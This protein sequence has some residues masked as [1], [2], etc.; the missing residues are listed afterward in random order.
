MRTVGLIALGLMF[1]QNVASA[2]TNDNDKPA[3]KISKP[4]GGTTGVVGAAGGAIAPEFTPLTASERWKRYFVDAFG[5]EAIVRAAASGGVNQWKGTPKEWGGGAE[6]FGERVGNSYAEHIIRKT[7]EAGAAAALHEDNR[8]I[9]STETAFWKRSKHAI[10]SVFV[11]RN[12]AGQE[13]FA[14]SRFGSAWGES[15]ISRTWQPR[16]V[17]SAGDATV[18][19]GITMAADMGWNAVREFWPNRF[20]RH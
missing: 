12:E 9:R 3:V 20:K 5:P 8:Y 14:Y 6:A 19:F 4:D 17:N 13:H 1:W 11:A 15:F 2:Q 18:H 16:S 7:L 10:T